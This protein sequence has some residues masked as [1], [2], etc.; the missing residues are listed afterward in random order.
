[1]TENENPNPAA[2]PAPEPQ[3]G[4]VAE[5][6]VESQTVDLNP[7][8]VDLNGETF[9]EGDVEDTASDEEGEPA[10]PQHTE[11]YDA[12]GDGVPDFDAEESD[13][14]EVQS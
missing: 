6:N 10:Q 9:Y 5:D 11:V 7:D 12:D 3:T 13:E 14:D 1:M 8:E 2:S 4:M